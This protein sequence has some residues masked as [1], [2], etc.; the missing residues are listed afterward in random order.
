VTD[1][2]NRGPFY[3]HVLPE[4]QYLGITFDGFPAKVNTVDKSSSFYGRILP[5]QRVE[6]V[7]VPGSADLK[8]ESG[9]FTGHRVT[10]HLNPSISSEGINI[11]CFCRRYHIASEM[12]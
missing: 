2:G 4:V 10:Q 3:S 9:G 6:A 12:T 7:V 11:L 8:F 1:S 5:G